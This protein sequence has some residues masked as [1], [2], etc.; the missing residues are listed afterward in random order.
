M[1]I[2][3]NNSGSSSQSGDR[4]YDVHY[5]TLTLVDHNF[6]EI[7]EGPMKGNDG[8]FW[9]ATDE[10]GRTWTET[11]V[12]GRE[13]I[14]K[15]LIPN[16]IACFEVDNIC[17]MSKDDPEYKDCTGMKFRVKSNPSQCGKY[18]NYRMWPPNANGNHK[19]FAKG[20]TS[21]QKMAEKR[22]KYSK[23]TNPNSDS[24]PPF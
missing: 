1:S 8:L 16:L 19:K 3:S 4:I 14:D 23:Y 5:T 12:F 2:F 7:N 11:Q 15:W 21:A 22:A 17:Q 6:G 20:Q 9:T 24:Q 13:D 18:P 10:D